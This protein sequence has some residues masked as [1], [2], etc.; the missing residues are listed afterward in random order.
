MTVFIDIGALE[1]IPRQG[2]RVIR[3]AQGC[4]AVF[5]T[6][7]DRVFALD[8]RCP[9]KGGPL[10][11]GIVHG[12]RVTCPLHNWVFDMNSGTA[13]GADEGAV[14]TWPVRVE[15]GRILISAELVSRPRA[16]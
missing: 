14:R 8:D 7:D 9:H 4:V 13:Q 11:E 12:D 5:R 2:A 3:T 10:S 6:M 15:Q 1:D 16:A